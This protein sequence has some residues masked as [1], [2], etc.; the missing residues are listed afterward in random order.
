MP[1]EFVATA[2]AD[3]IGAGLVINVMA[4]VVPPAATLSMCHQC[5]CFNTADR[6]A[7]SE[8]VAHVVEAAPEG[9]LAML[10]WPK[11]P[12]IKVLTATAA[13]AS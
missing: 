2:A 8:R 11:D 12:R 10:D 3:V 5:S 6:K 9:I 7:L 13:A 4:V 1:E